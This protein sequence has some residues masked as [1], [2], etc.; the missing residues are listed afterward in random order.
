MTRDPAKRIPKSIGTDAKLLGTYTLTDLAVGLLPGVLVVL[1]TQL[2]LPAD[3]TVAGHPLQTLT[4]PVAGVAI[5]VGGLFVYLT[6]EYTS[7]VDWLATFIGFQR[8]PST[9]AHEEAKGLT[10]VER[11]HPAANALERVDGALVGAVRVQPASLALATDDEW[12]ATADAFQDFLNTVIEFPVQFYATTQT[13]PVE[14]YLGHF[15]SRLTDPDVKANPRLATLIEE[16]TA[17]YGTD[18]EQRRPTIRDH[19]VLVPVAPREVQFERESLTQQ[20]ARLPV[21]G[22]FIAMWHA[23]RQ[24]ERHQAMVDALNERLRRVEQGLREI[25]GCNAHR[26]DAA[27]LAQLVGEFWTGESL[28]ESDLSRTLRSQSLLRGVRP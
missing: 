27:A 13:F 18:L 12:V 9:L 21:L 6:P 8:R 1:V 16:Y 2:V 26:V 14:D 19:Y 15:R 17:W 7:S 25:D 4:L 10:Q 28:D 22:V 3:T 11:V 24:E 5:A 20:L 23:P